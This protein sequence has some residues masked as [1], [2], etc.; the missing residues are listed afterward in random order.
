M[1]KKCENILRFSFFFHVD[2]KKEENNKVRIMHFKCHNLTSC[3]QTC[4]LC[5]KKKSSQR[6][7]YTGKHSLCLW[8]WYLLSLKMSNISNQKPKGCD[9]M[10]CH[11]IFQHNKRA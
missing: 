3:F 7:I 10:F 11:D 2:K 9:N 5:I 8:Y 1:Y 4:P 6:F